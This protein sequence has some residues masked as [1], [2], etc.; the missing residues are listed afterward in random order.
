MRLFGVLVIGL[1]VWLENRENGRLLG[2]KQNKCINDPIL[3]GNDAFSC[4]CQLY[5]SAKNFAHKFSQQSCRAYFSTKT[6]WFSDISG[7]LYSTRTCISETSA[8][9]VSFP[10]SHLMNRG[11]RRQFYRRHTRYII[12]VNSQASFSA[13]LLLSPSLPTGV[14]IQY[15]FFA[16]NTP[17]TTARASSASFAP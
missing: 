17:E 6:V 14:E 10:H 1:L 13:H 3:I 12:Q 2:K 11:N 15:R 7:V 4:I 16:I 5:V 9:E 8:R